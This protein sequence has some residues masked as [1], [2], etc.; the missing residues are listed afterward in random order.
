MAQTEDGVK[1]L[2]DFVLVV[3]VL[4]QF[5]ALGAVRDRSSFKCV[6][7]R[8]RICEMDEIHNLRT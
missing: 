5:N 3:L 2:D 7:A 4:G 6:H 1:P 8:L